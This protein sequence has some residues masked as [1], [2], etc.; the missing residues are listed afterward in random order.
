MAEPSV[1]I[2]AVYSS[3]MAGDNANPTRIVVHATCPTLWHPVASAAGQALSTARYFAGG[4]AG[5]SAHY[6]VDIAGEQ[7]CV[8]DD[9]MAYHAP[10][11]QRSIGIEICADGGLATPNYPYPYTREQWLSPQVLPAL[12]R[13]AERV[14]ELCARHGIPPIRIGPTALRNGSRGICGHVDVSAAWRQTDHSDPGPNFPWPE[15]M[16]LVTGGRVTTITPEDTVPWRLERTPAK[17]LSKA[18]DH[19]DASFVAVEDVIA[20]PG[21]AS[22]WR[23]RIICHV[24]FGYGGG[25]VQEAWWS[26]GGAVVGKT[27]PRYIDQFATQSWEAPTGARFLTLRY[28]APAGGSVGIETEH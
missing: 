24:M 1:T 22:G 9:T 21:P 5:G 13:A 2:R 19:P 6:I 12:R 28:A 20:L 25:F 17:L 27:T 4:T 3:F 18:G 11:N 14:S 7:H 10:P 26:V 15:F 16:A 23:G 8:P